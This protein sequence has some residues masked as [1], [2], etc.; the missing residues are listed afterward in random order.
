M[1]K[2]QFILHRVRC[3]DRE[4]RTLRNNIT[5]YER[6][7]DS[8]SVHLLHYGLREVMR[9]AEPGRLVDFLEVLELQ[10]LHGVKR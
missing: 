7:I 8:R 6:A 9:T 3:V 4:G 10:R 5:E 1:V 2:R